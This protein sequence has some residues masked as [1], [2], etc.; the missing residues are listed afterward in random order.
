M[1][2][3]QKQIN[4]ILL[5]LKILLI[6]LLLQ[7][8]L[9]TFISFELNLQGGFW[10]IIW[11]RKEVFIAILAIITVFFFSK[12][13]QWKFFMKKSSI[14]WFIVITILS[15]ILIIGISLFATKIELSTLIMSLRYSFSGF[16]IFIVC[17]A[18]GW[19]F[20]TGKKINLVDRYTKIIKILLV[21]WIFRRWIIRL[22]PKL[23]S[24]VGYDHEIYEGNV[25]ASPPAVYYTQ[26]NYGYVRNQFLF[27]RPI[28]RGFFLIAFWPIF[29][30]RIIKNKGKLNLVIRGGLYGL[31]VLSTFS[32]A[33]RITRIFLTFIL[34]LTQY[35]RDFWK[36]AWYFLIPVIVILAGVT[37]MW[38][39]DIIN[40][41]F[42]NT[43]HFQH[44]E[45][46]ISHIKE[47]PILWVWAGS[48][49]PASHISE[50]FVG[51]NPEN[52]FLQIWLE[53][54]L[55]WFLWWMILYIRL[56]RI[57]LKAFFQ[58]R[59]KNLSKQQKNQQRMIIWFSM[60]LL[61]L[62]IEWLVLHSFVDRMIVYPFMTLF[63]IMYAIYVKQEKYRELSDGKI[64]IE[65]K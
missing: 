20:F 2:I 63:G 36:S 45:T 40:R 42:S 8:F 26:Y 22:I 65:G 19:I 10:S 37:Y 1:K 48:A 35:K 52:Q 27:E 33:A 7:F 34:I 24:F 64:V 11:M 9:N 61:W 4:N 28:S 5:I 57:G 21:L 18:I 39:D 12:N 32:R 47:H 15:L 31:N 6:W 58:L 60:G 17:F 62:S 3:S 56:H 29:F 59:K 53:Y 55:F 41:K 43:W 16:I 25:G 44:I 13:K 38:K 51:Y 49:G 46:A 50:Q 14:K 54:W 30:L 23:L